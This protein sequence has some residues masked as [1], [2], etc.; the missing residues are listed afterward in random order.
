MSPDFDQINQALEPWRQGD[1][2]L[3]TSLVFVHVANLKKPLTET[4]QKAAAYYNSE[5]IPLQIGEVFQHPPGFVVVTQTCDLARNCDERPYINIAPLTQVESERLEEIQKLKR[6]GYLYIPSLAEQGLVGDLDRIMTLE[7]AIVA[8]WDRIPGWSTDSEAKNIA[9]AISRKFAR[10]AFPDDF[11]AA[12]QKFTKRVKNKY[13]KHN[14]EG[15]HLKSLREIRVQAYPSWDAAKVELL[16]WLIQD[17]NPPNPVQWDSLIDEWSKLID[18]SGRFEVAMQKTTLDD[19]TARDYTDSDTLDFD[20][21]S[22][23]EELD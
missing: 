11:V 19:M 20:A 5:N 17:E 4:A 3:G 7:K 9:Q 14:P 23:I 6:P 16:F 10:M 15:Q 12:I 2:V 22:Y 21:L 8:E 1:V 13:T 18:E